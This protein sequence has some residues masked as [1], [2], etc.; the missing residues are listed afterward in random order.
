VAE[1]RGERQ[2]EATQAG[3][4]VEADAALAREL[5]K[6]LDRVDRA[7]RIGGRRADDEDR[8]LGDRLR[9]RG[10]VGA[11]V[12]PHRDVHGL[13]A[14]ALRGLVERGVRGLRQH[15]LRA[16][17]ARAVAVRLDG[18]HDRLGAAGGD[19]AADVLAAAEHARGHGDDLCLEL[20]RARPQVDVQRVALR[21]QL[22]HA[23]EELHVLGI[24]VVDGA[25]R[26]PVVP[27]RALL[28]GHRRE[29]GQHLLA[30]PPLLGQ[31]V[32]RGEAVAVRAQGGDDLGERVGHRGSVSRTA[33]S[34]R[35]VRRLER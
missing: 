4:G 32:E 13:D 31:A 15:H 16:L 12:R 19:D 27:L 10:D 33:A 3:V 8:A 1:P 14:Q 23:A 5:R 7:V 29:L 20:R 18:E 21:V 30:R 28:G 2:Q 17:D 11:E 6:L 35:R 26:V 22:V 25:R 9:G 34:R 24:A